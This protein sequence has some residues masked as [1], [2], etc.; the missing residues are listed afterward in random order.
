MKCKKCKS[1]WNVSATISEC[2]VCKASLAEPKDKL[3]FDNLHD[4]LA[5]IYADE[6]YGLDVLLGDR[7]H[8]FITDYYPGIKKLMKARVK[9]VSTSGAA[10]FLKAAANSSK[11]EKERAI[12]L[13]IQRLTDEGDGKDTATDIIYEYVSVLN[14]GITKLQ[15]APQ[16]EQEFDP[17]KPIIKKGKEKRIGLIAGVTVTLLI[18][19]IGSFNSSSLFPN[20]GESNSPPIIPVANKETVLA[21]AANTAVPTTT[22]I[23]EASLEIYPERKRSR[24]GMIEVY[25]PAGEFIM[26]S[27]DSDT[28]ADNNEKPVRKVKLSDYWIDKYEV[29]EAQYKHC[30]DSGKCTSPNRS[31]SRVYSYPNHP[32]TS[33][34]WNQAKAYCD[35]VGGD[36]PTE[37]QWEK[38][39]RGPN[40][41]KY[42][43]GNQEP[44]NNF[45]NYGQ[46]IGGTSEVGFYEKGESY[47]GA[48][49]MAGNVWEWVNDGYGSYDINTTNNPK[50]DNSSVYKVLRG[51]SYE[52]YSYRSLRSAKRHINYPNYWDNNIGFRCVSSR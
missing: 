5:A 34:N 32:I 52:N 10:G 33:V 47:Y 44:D 4:A 43:W 13:A 6:K 3:V 31:I 25:V 51:G 24:D 42:P 41:N 17:P 11:A 30:V 46:N 2:P 9:L 8:L 18:I 39:A 20:L 22:Q 49:D 19:I 29:T 21:I 28:D 48:M 23:T 16:L 12:L 15:P 14:W 45:A 50:G 35:W 26:G 37:A 27:E 1:E 40:G 7:C 36:L 38:A